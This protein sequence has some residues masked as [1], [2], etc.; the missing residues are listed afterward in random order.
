MSSA[1]CSSAGLNPNGPGLV[2]NTHPAIAINQVNTVRPAGVGDLGSIVE[3]VD[4][5]RK[6]DAELA[7][8]RARYIRALSFILRTGKDD[9]VADVALHLP[10]VAGMRFQD[11]HG[12][13]RHPVSVLL[14]ELVEGGNL[15][16]EWRSSVAAEHQHN[17]LLAPEGREL[18]LTLVV[19]SRQ[20]KVW[21]RRHPRESCRRERASRKFRTG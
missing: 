9:R 8:A 18:D 14:V 13:E 20:L 1:A 6:F 11:V 7:H 2:L 5:C 12:V 21:S 3:A 16:P 10:N 19:E 4:D 17:R 15:P